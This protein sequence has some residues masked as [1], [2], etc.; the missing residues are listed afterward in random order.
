MTRQQPSQRPSPLTPTIQ[1]YH[2]SLNKSL[3]TTLELAFETYQNCTMARLRVRY[4]Q[5]ASEKTTA[6]SWTVQNLEQPQEL[7][8]SWKRF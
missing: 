5:G 6:A 1:V 3:E 7:L 4:R 8:S 2:S